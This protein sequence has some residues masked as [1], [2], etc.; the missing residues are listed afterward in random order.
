LINSTLCETTDSVLTPIVEYSSEIKTIK[1]CKN[2]T[3]NHLNQDRETQHTLQN[4]ENCHQVT[5]H[6]KN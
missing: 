1:R 5:A 2:V 6:A 4:A 3:D